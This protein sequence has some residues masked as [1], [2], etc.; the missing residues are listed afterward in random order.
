MVTE[1][2]RN[3]GTEEGEGWRD[4]T[5]LVFCWR[6]SVTIWAVRERNTWLYGAFGA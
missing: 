1:E 5:N 2:R 3:E 4:D 6:R